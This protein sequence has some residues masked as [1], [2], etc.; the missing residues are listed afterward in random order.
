MINFIDTLTLPEASYNIAPEI[1][2]Q[3]IWDI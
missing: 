1:T 2:V 3:S